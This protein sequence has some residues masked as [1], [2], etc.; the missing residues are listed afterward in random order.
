VIPDD[1]RCF[2]QLCPHE[3]VGLEAI[4]AHIEADHFDGGDDYTPERR[5]DGGLVV[6]ASDV[7]ELI[8]GASE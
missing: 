7:P 8:Q 4:V 2:C 3:T 5:P 6:D 1:V